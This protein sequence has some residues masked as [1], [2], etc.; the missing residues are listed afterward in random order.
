M[1]VLPIKILVFCILLPPLFYIATL[2][3]VESYLQQRWADDIENVYTGDTRMLLNG[4]LRL[5]DAIRE[6]ISRFLSNR[7]MVRAGVRAVVTVVTKNGLLLYPP[8][9]EAPVADVMTADPM[10]IAAE[11]YELMNQGLKVSV[12]VI[13]DHNTILSNAI[14][15]FWVSVSLVLMAFFYR[16]GAQA[17]R[18]QEEEKNREIDLLSVQEQTLSR[19]LEKL[20]GERARLENRY[21]EAVR[22]LETEKVKATQNEDSMFDE[23]EKLEEEI[24]R[25]I[26]LQKEQQEEIDRLKVEIERVEQEGGKGSRHAQKN[27]ALAKKRFST[28]YKN[29]IMHK[30]AL[31]GYSDLKEDMKIKSE[32]II[33]QLNSDPALVP[34]KRKVFS[35]KSRE[36]VFEVLFAYKG[37][38]YYRKT[39]GNKIEILTI[40]TKNSQQRDLEFLDSL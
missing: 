32:E 5:Q 11:N 34:V 15:V 35:K 24:R 18:R 28:I 9:Y 12:E 3:L 37:R 1:R 21:E 25:N 2:L 16:R 40:G 29:V 6:N 23:M 8:V 33:H 31:K 7:M 17:M 10:N 20:S 39:H 13:L 14:L 36:T 38:L 26:D 19:M 30:K 4:S 22:R 27:D